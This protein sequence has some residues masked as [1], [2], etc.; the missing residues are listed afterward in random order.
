M[1]TRQ[2]NVR[3]K[4]ETGFESICCVVRSD[5]NPMVMTD[6]TTNFH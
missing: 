5:V 2:P 1:G 6:D 4:H 3:V